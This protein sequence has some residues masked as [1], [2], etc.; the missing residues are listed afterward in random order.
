MKCL[1]KSIPRKVIKTLYLFN[2][3]SKNNFLKKNLL[4]IL[5]KH[6]IFKHLSFDDIFIMK[7]INFMK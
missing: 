3:N 5:I 4:I 2:L 6:L 7:F 1:L